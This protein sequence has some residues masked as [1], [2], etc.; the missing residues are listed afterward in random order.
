M[1]SDAVGIGIAILLGLLSISVSI[2]FGLRGFRKDLGGD[3]STIREKTVIIQETV[4]NVWEVV[5]ISPALGAS[6]TVERELKNLGR[7]KISAEFHE[8]MTTYLLEASKPAFDAGLIDRLS[9][10]TG[11]ATKE[12]EMF[13][14]AEPRLTDILPN[15]LKVDVP[16]T[17]AKVCTTYI[18]LLLKWLDTTYWEKW[19]KLEDFEEPIDV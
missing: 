17:D 12:R 9:K 4:R 6:G 14:G 18:S 11:L 13:G 7:I 1:D 8:S 15:K 3:I 10:E 2:Y 16:S 5:R 19:P